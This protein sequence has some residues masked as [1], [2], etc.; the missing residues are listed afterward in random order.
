MTVLMFYIQD[1]ARENIVRLL[2]KG[3]VSTQQPEWSVRVNSVD[4]GLCEQDLE[5]VL[6]AKHLPATVLL[7]K[8]DHPEHIEW[9]SMA[10]SERGLIIG[11]IVGDII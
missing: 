10:T 1:V 9:V 3:P 7:P 11:M 5:A 6:T 2:N 8:V 4:S